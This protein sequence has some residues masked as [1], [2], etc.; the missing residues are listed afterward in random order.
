MPIAQSD[1]AEA[2][3]AVH[4]A[5]ATSTTLRG[6]QSA[7]PHLILWGCVYF[8]AYTVAYVR[9]A[10]GGWAWLVLVPLASIGDGVIASRDR[11]KQDGKW[12]VVLVLFATFLAFITATGAIMQ[13]QDPK[14]MAAFV[15]LLVAACYIVLGVGVGQRLIYTGV[16]LGVLTLVGFFAFPAIFMLW[17][18]AVGGGALILGG[19]WL[20]RV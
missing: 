20:G 2:L 4:Q 19:I 13:P 5:E 6:Y 18:A 15:P 7:A 11:A 14:Q 10:W 1:A 3:R 8:C 16:A 12:G 9:P 17:M